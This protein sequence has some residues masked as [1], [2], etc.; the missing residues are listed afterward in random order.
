[1]T[2]SQ[3]IYAS[4]QAHPNSVTPFASPHEHAA[5]DPSY[6]G[7]CVICGGAAQGGIPKSLF[8]SQSY[9]DWAYHKAPPATHVCTGCAFCMLLNMTQRRFG[10]SRYP[11][12]AS[13]SHGLRLL[14]FP[15]IKP[16]LLSPPPPPFVAVVAV[17][18]QKHLAT[19]AHVSYSQARFTV[20]L[21]EEA[22]SVSLSEFAAC[23]RL[24]DTL[25]TMG[26]SRYDIAV[27]NLS[28]AGALPSDIVD[29]LS[30]F[31]QSRTFALALYLASKSPQTGQSLEDV[32]YA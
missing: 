12:I 4:F 28:S 6:N 23:S 25:Y 18:R 1:M 32:V 19:K 15:D 5:Y 14:S 13:Q 11:F 31:K 9:T 27:A 2:A 10:L 7:P 17:S 29:Q 21:E 22:I 8:F 24:I 26:L 3:L 16:A 20:M 30:S